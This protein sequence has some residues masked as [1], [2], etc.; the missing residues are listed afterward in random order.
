MNTSGCTPEAAAG[1]PNTALLVIDVQQGLF[2]KSTPIYQA[3]KLIANITALVEQAHRTGIPVVYV[4]HSDKR[5]LIQGS[6]E[7]QLHPELQ[8]LDTDILVFK[9]HGNAFEETNLG[10]VLESQK[11]GRVVAMGLVTHGCVKATCL[12]GQCIGLPRHPRA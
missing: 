1:R 11:V 3:D 9:Q 6:P 2:Q 4:Q 7:W 12:G 8:P 5:A 10:E